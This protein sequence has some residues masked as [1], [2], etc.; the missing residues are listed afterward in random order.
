MNCYER[1]ITKIGR[2]RKESRGPEE[3]KEVPLF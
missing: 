1:P 2:R 3:E